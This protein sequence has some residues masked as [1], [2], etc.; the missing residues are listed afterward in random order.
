MRTA[1]EVGNYDYLLD[2]VFQQN[3]MI[4]VMVGATGLDAVKGVAVEVDARPH[5]RRGHPLTAR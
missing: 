2:Y 5:R 3:G 4:R 1:S